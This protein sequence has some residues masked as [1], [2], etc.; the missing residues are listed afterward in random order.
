MHDARG[1]ADE[2][3]DVTVWTAGVRRFVVRSPSSDHHVEVEG[4][5]RARQLAGVA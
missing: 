1:M 2:V 3:G 4:F 5:E